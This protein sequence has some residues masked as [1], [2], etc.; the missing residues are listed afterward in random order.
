[1]ELSGKEHCRADKL[2][3]GVGFAVH[4]VAFM[5]EKDGVLVWGIVAATLEGSFGITGGLYQSTIT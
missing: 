5:D 2:L 1:M 3:D 4:N